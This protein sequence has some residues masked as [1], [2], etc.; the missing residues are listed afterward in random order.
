VDGL[1]GQDAEHEAEA[2]RFAANQLIPP[3]AACQL[4]GLRSEVEVRAAAQT[5]GIAP[6][7][8]VG[9]LQHEG[10]LPRTHLN[11][12]K[13]SYQWPELK[14]LVDGLNDCGVGRPGA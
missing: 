10:W 9:R 6:G 2:N 7:I 14:A 1:D 8:V 12:L 5:L 4:R 11:G 3:T 13:V